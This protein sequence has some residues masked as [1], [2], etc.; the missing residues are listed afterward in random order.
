MSCPAITR[1][2]SDR[3]RRIVQRRQVRAHVRAC[4]GCRAFAVAIHRRKADLR[5]ISPQ[6]PPA[7]ASRILE[8]ILGWDGGPGPGKPPGGLVRP[9]RVRHRGIRRRLRAP[10]AVAGTAAVATMV[11]SVLVRVALP[12]PR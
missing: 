3:D 2:L 9:A 7:E 4:A 8:T 5:E 10:A 1:D 11:A 12:R 6:L